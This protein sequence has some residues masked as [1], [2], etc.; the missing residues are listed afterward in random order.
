LMAEFPFKSTDDTANTQTFNNGDDLTL[1][2]GGSAPT[3]WQLDIPAGGAWEF[4]N[5]S[6][7]GGFAT[8]VGTSADAVLDS[9]TKTFTL[10][11]VTNRYNTLTTTQWWLLQPDQDNLIHY[12]GPNGAVLE[13]KDTW[14]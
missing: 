11:G 4:T 14:L 8:L 12:E 9:Q 7:G 10:G 6:I 3:P 2:I 1:A 13:W 5:N